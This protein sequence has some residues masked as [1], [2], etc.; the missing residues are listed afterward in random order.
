MEILNMFDLGQRAI[1]SN[2][3]CF[4]CI[5]NT[6]MAT[7]KCSHCAIALDYSFWLLST[8][9][10]HRIIPLWVHPYSLLYIIETLI[11][12][13]WCICHVIQSPKR[14]LYSP[15]YFSKKPTHYFL[16]QRGEPTELCHRN[17]HRN[18]TIL[19]WSDGMTSLH[20][21]FMVFPLKDHFSIKN[22]LLD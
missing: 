8:A 18:K 4:F 19:F 7:D 6:K 10:S 17:Y 15:G 12:T 5:E 1:A 3:S 16:H 2:F 20:R 13:H 21:K 22:A 14:I 11:H 9:P